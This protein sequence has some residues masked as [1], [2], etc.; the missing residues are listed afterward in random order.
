M[1]NEPFDATGAADAFT[2]P[3]RKL[4][5]LVN[6]RLAYKNWTFELKETADPFAYMGGPQVELTW[7]H[8]VVD[9]HTG[10]PITVAGRRLIL[11]PSPYGAGTDDLTRKVLIAEIWTVVV[12][13]ETHEAMEHFQLGGV[14][15]YDPHPG[16][17]S[18]TEA[19]VFE[20]NLDGLHG[21]APTP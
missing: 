13:A 11:L 21:K 1:S 17:K 14:C 18:A 20:P 5:A 2:F 10:Q 8:P 6:E 7:S 16:G 12:A 9:R 15:V 19:R 4:V 3:F